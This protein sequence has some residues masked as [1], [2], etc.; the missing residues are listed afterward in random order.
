MRHFKLILSLALMAWVVLPSQ[1]QKTVVHTPLFQTSGQSMWGPFPNPGLNQTLEIFPEFRRD[2]PF[3]TESFTVLEFS[4]L[5]FGAAL[6]GNVGFGVGPLQFR[7]E[8]FTLGDVGITYPAEV[9]IIMP[10]D[11]TFNP[12]E[13]ITIRSEF[14][15]GNGAEIITNY[16]EAGTVVLDM[17][18]YFD[19]SLGFKAC[20]IDC[21]PRVSIIPPPG[22]SVPSPLID[23]AF[24]FFEV[25][26]TTGLT[27]ICNDPAS[28]FQCNTNTG[29]PPWSY[30]AGALSG[31]VSIPHVETTTQVLG[32]GRNLRAT[33]DSTYVDNVIDIVQLIGY[34]PGAQSVT[35][36]LSFS[37]TIPIL[38][39]VTGNVRGITLGWTL[40]TINLLFPITHNQEFNFEPRVFT[41]LEFPEPIDYTIYS[42]SEGNI[43]GSS[44]TI[45]YQVGDSVDITFPCFFDFMDVKAKH[46]IEGQFSNKTFDNFQVALGFE[47]L[48]FEVTIDP[49]IIIPEICIPIPFVGDLCTPEIGFPGAS[50]NIGPLISPPPF[51]L[52]DQD[53][54]PYFDRNWE[55]EGFN[56]VEIAQPFRLIP[57]RRTSEFIVQDVTCHGDSTG[58]ILTDIPNAAA[59]LTY[60]WSFGSS[61]PNPI[62]IPAGVHYLKVTDANN[63]VF[64]ESV[65]INQPDELRVDMQADEILCSGETTA[66]VSVTASGGVGP[67]TYQWNTL[68]N[69]PTLSNRG[70]G[71][72]TVTITDGIGCQIVDSVRVEEPFPLTVEIFNPIAPSCNG[73]NDGSLDLLVDG[74]SPPYSFLWS[75]NAISGSLENIA[76]GFYEVTVTDVKGCTVTDFITIAEPTV[77]TGA[78]DKS[79]D[80]NCFA[81]SS[82]QMS[83]DVQGGTPPYSYTWLNDDV[84]LNTAGPVIGDLVV[85]NYSVEVLDAR[86]CRLVLT[87]QV[88]GPTN[89]LEAI[90]TPN[91][92]DCNDAAT[93]SI[94]L[95]V[96]GGTPPYMYNW[97]SGEATEDLIDVPA[98]RYQVEVTD[99]NGCSVATKTLLVETEQIRA[100]YFI[101]NVSCNEQQDGYVDIQTIKGGTPPYSISWSTGDTT[102]MV[103]NLSEGAV[104]LLITDSNDCQW[105]TDIEIMRSEIACLFIP[106]TFSPNADGINDVWNI[107]N[108]ELYPEVSIRV[109]NRWGNTVFESNGYQQP[110]DGRSNGSDLEPATYYYMVDLRNGDPVYS[111]PLTI[112]K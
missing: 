104:G 6:D 91:H 57:R 64:F 50:L 1:A 102:R 75:N 31:E 46:F 65:E 107:R 20:F 58:T 18:V 49:Y 15:A 83:V 29:F 100:G 45:R 51:T 71:L 19:A 72:Y 108:I 37:R 32:G 23:S 26:P 36:I 56:D 44:T 5:E 98:G 69:T 106:N 2:F 41:E 77:M 55:I 43:S 22:I 21:T 96:T 109:V 34:I 16:P 79:S 99:A 86:G 9:S 68:D 90:L 35:S 87:E 52:V 73:E 48:E 10:D 39:D 78:I 42:S 84:K 81:G 40:A 63:C 67:Y 28:L 27:Y 82:A 97:E 94:D 60:E 4:G 38:P 11:S 12:G 3:N 62:N 111:G 70:A 95:T 110:W 54:P 17:G 61:D 8:G 59:P 24:K 88:T 80:V 76:Q 101:G 53:F 30:G 103:E 74:G 85:G 13:T 105:F 7:I 92:I 93:G 112:V 89:P 66:E 25:N 47:A 33:G 14:Q